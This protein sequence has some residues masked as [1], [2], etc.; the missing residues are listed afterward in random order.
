MTHKSQLKTQPPKS[1]TMRNARKEN[2]KENKQS[3]ETTIVK[4]QIIYSSVILYVLFYEE[5]WNSN[6]SSQ[7]L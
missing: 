2:E 4:F 6:H 7:L 1:N 5:N 3:Q